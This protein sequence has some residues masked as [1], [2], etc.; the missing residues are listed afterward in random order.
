MHIDIG[1]MSDIDTFA[2]SEYLGFI[3][4]DFVI[5]YRLVIAG[6]QIFSLKFWKQEWLAEAPRSWHLAE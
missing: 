1:Y 4:D 3:E 2:F 6:T 5:I